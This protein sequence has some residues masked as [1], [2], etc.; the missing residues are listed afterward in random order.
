MNKEIPKVYDAQKVED[1]IY[2]IWEKS[3]FFNPDNLQGEKTFTISMPPPN[4]TGQ[5]HIGHAMFLTLQDLMIRYHRMLGEKTLWLP[6]T[7]HAAIAT[8][9]KVEKILASEGKTKHDLGQDKFIERVQEYI[10]QSKTTIRK[11]IKK[12]GS[13][14]DWSRERYT[15]DEGLTQAVQTQFI[16][17]YNDGLIYKGYRIV[18][19]CPHC[20]STLADD[21]VEYKEQKTKLYYFKYSKDFPI[22]IAT[23]RPET[24]LGDTAVAVNPK[25]ERYQQYI[26]KSYEVDFV[27]VKLNIQII[28]DYNIEK[29]FGTGALGVTPAHS[30]IDWQMAEK[31][32]LKKIKVIDEQG[33]IC[34]DF[35]EYSKL[36]IE[37]AREKIIANLKQKGLL[38]KEED[39]QNNLSICYRCANVIEPLP[40]KQWFVKVA[41]LKKKAITVVKKGEI[42]F[43]PER[44]S[45]IYFHWM[46]NLHDWCISR[47]I[48]FGHRMPVWYKKE[49]KEKNKPIVQVENPGK[50]YIQE[51]D[52]L[53]TWFSSGLWTFSTLGWPNKTNDL[54]T[55]HP[56]TVMETGYDIIFFWV[57]RMILMSLHAL[58]DVPFKTVYLHGLVRTKD[59]KK[60][61]KSHPETC[62]DPLD[63]IAKYGCDAIRLA[64]IVGN[65]P[66]NDLRIYDEKIANYR[67]FINKL[68]NISRFIMMNSEK[69][70]IREL[71]IHTLADQ[72]IMSRLQKVIQ[73]V[74]DNIDKYNFGQAGD[75]L[76][77]FIWHDFADWYIEITKFQPNQPLLL[78][79]LENILMLLHPFAPFVTEE[80][81]QNFQQKNL[82][83]VTKWPKVQNKLTNDKSEKEFNLL[84]DIIIQIRNLKAQYKI[85][86]KKIISL[87]TKEKI[88]ADE[89]VIIEKLA[90][91][92]VNHEQNHEGTKGS[93]ITKINNSQYSFTAVLGELI[94]VD[95][96]KKRL[97][98]EIEHLSANIANL[99]RR[100]NN[101]NFIARAPKNI[102][103]LEQKNLAERKKLLLNLEKNWNKL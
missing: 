38:E 30:A 87:Y 72:W 95:K 50:D 75:D 28:A 11:Q 90:R 34:S 16:N 42:K 66:G 98:K 12:M 23:T 68:W 88:P 22:T 45:K 80:I 36:S 2:E 91:C 5:L 13:S 97:E 78:Y 55:F 24:K 21:E 92:Q 48:W 84:Q 3:G 71:S 37:Q 60:M 103:E 14:C 89:K 99:E 4:A 94:D 53:D 96:E 56:T 85:E 69:I 79:I 47:Q 20:E 59:G 41:D 76:Y 67:N 77:N 9:A 101:K 81:W 19:W 74:T 32:N 57:A 8:N 43:V 1:N 17:M 26:G 100:L 10:E 61:S 73:S 25:D 63:A 64:L 29:E 46:E 58:D 102:I 15:M 18:N 35:G 54:K 49:D 65:S 51:S 7:D 82:L 62:I 93:R 83:L 70:E 27:G 52:T 44:F 40:S 39:I 6:G 33:I 86:P 31:N